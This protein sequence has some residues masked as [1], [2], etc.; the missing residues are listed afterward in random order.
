MVARGETW[1]LAK[2]ALQG[3]SD[4]DIW[5][6]LQ[7]AYSLE[8]QE[9][10]LN[11]ARELLHVHAGKF[12]HWA[13]AMENI[14]IMPEAVL[15]HLD[16]NREALKPKITN[17]IM[18]LAKKVSEDEC[19]KCQNFVGTY[20]RIITLAGILPGT[21]DMAKKSLVEIINA[22]ETTGKL[23]FHCESHR[24]Y[25]QIQYEQREFLLGKLKE[26]ADQEVKMCLICINRGSCDRHIV[27][28]D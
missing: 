1:L 23:A 17:A 8:L 10:F 15:D 12:C 4:Y 19:N 14:G 13:F 9:S 24:H 21:D 7:F 25:K 18:A 27:D 5:Y 20:I 6:L 26:C 3:H 28:K 2:M 16:N 22:A 11:L